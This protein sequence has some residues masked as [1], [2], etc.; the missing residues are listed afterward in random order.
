LHAS[1]RELTPVFDRTQQDKLDRNWSSPGKPAV[2]VGVIG[3][4][5][6]P[7]RLADIVS[8]LRGVSVRVSL[9]VLTDS[10]G[11]SRLPF[12]VHLI[13]ATSSLDEFLTRW[14]PLGPDILIDAGGSFELSSYANAQLLL[15][16]RYLR[17]IPLVFG[18]EGNGSA[19]K[20]GTNAQVIES[21]ILAACDPAYRAE[22]WHW[23]EVYCAEAF[24]PDQNVRV[25]AEIVARGQP[26]DTVSLVARLRK[27][28]D[29]NANRTVLAEG[30][31]HERSRRLAKAE[32]EL[33][34]RSYR[35]ALRLRKLA[36]WVRRVNGSFRLR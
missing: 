1:V 14:K 22:K 12:P 30:E 28:L 26:V 24:A 27:M 15:I 34:S 7:D 20:D 33:A 21:A 19:R 4:Q 3:S 9:E 36:N 25:L 5:S 35:V 16:A 17:A 32:M 8:A 11:L 18:N 23:L 31:L 10:T 6:Q 29:Y 2:R 13:G